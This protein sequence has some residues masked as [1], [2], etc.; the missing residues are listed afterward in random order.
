M[1][2]IISL[3][4]R[5]LLASLF[6]AAGVDH[7]QNFDAIVTDFN[8]HEIFSCDVLLQQE[9]FVQNREVIVQGLV[10]L[11]LFLQ[12]AG[13]LLV[14]LNSKLGYLMLIAFTVPVTYVHHAFWESDTPVQDMH[15]FMKNVALVGALLAL[16]AAGCSKGP[17]APAASSGP[18]SKKKKRN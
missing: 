7:V 9:L 11:A 3:V 17:C 13:G 18:V 14:V 4:G 8:Q 1:A 2:C 5:I 6:I 15:H 10:G 16:L 12:I